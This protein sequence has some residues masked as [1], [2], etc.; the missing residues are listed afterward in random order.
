MHPLGLWGASCS[1]GGVDGR[2][3][4][5]FGTYGVVKKEDLWGEL[6]SGHHNG[7]LLLRILRIRI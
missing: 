6:S 3:I 5:L 7:L 2:N 1:L 4:R